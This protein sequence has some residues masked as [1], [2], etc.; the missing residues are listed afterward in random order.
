MSGHPGSGFLGGPGPPWFLE[1]RQL[2]PGSLSMLSLVPCHKS[3]N[4]KVPKSQHLKILKAQNDFALHCFALLCIAL[5]CFALLRIALRP[6]AL[7]CIALHCFALHCS[8]LLCI[9]LLYIAWGFA[10]SA[11]QKKMMF[12]DILDF[13]DIFDFSLWGEE[14]GSG[15]PRNPGGPVPRGTRGA[16]RP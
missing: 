2:P 10:R 11:K 12:F 3:P 6:I 13:F 16:D 5:H 4:L 8:A 7:L 15:G 14:P 1:P 9:T